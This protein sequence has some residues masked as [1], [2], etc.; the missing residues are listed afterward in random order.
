MTEYL[1]DANDGDYGGGYGDSSIDAT[2]R[3]VDAG[4]DD[5]ERRVEAALR[6]RRL[7]EFPGQTR[8]CDQ[9]ALVLEAAK[10]RG[11]PEERRVG[12]SVLGV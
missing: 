8:V 6:P 11:T 2:A 5:D 1:S 9:L 10:R 7:S 3:I 4:G 12:K